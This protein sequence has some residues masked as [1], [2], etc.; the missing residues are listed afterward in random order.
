MTTSK[1]STEILSLGRRSNAEW[2][3]T[4]P[5]ERFTIRT[6]VKE[7]DG[8][9]TVLE[10]VADPRNGVPMHIHQNEDEHFIVLDG[11]LHIANGDTTLDA[12]AGTAVTVSKGV[13]HAW[14][15]LTDAPVRMLI[16]FSPGHIEGLFKKV[17]AR[18]SD[19]D[20]AAIAEKFGCLIV[21]PPLHEGIYSISSPRA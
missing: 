7:T 21:G 9:F 8:N 4:T 5:G 14:C 12:P 20:I 18:K 6:S 15:N 16:I 3:Q 13:P 17:A 19:D 1:K 10:V 2:L 11:T